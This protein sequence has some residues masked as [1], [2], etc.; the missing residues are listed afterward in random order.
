LSIYDQQRRLS[1]LQHFSKQTDDEPTF[2]AVT[3]FTLWPRA[4]SPLVFS[5]AALWRPLRCR[6]GIPKIFSHD[7]S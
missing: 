5:G 2:S 6:D 7:F 3:N 1:L 4:L